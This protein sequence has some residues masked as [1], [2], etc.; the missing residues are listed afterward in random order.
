MP[1]RIRISKSLLKEA[2]MDWRSTYNNDKIKILE[3]LNNNQ[4]GGANNTGVGAATL[5]LT[6]FLI[7]LVIIILIIFASYIVLYGA[8]KKFVEKNDE[9]KDLDLISVFKKSFLEFFENI[10]SIVVSLGKLIGITQ[11]KPA[12]LKS[13]EV[14]N[15][16]DNH[17]TYDE[18]KQACSML[19]SRLA[20]RA[21]VKGAYNKG[22]EWCNYGWSE[23]GEALYPTQEKTHRML[24]RAGRDGECGVPGVNGGYFYDKT[25]K[26]GANCYGVKPSPNSDNILSVDCSDP[27]VVQLLDTATGQ[28]GIKYNCKVDGR[29]EPKMDMNTLTSN[30]MPFNNYT[31]GEDSRSNRLYI[32]DNS[33]ARNGLSANRRAEG[34]AGGKETFSGKNEIDKT[35]LTRAL[36]EIREYLEGKPVCSKKMPTETLVADIKKLTSS[37]NP[38]EDKQKIVNV[39]LNKIMMIF[40]SHKIPLDNKKIDAAVNHYD[41]IMVHRHKREIDYKLTPFGINALYLKYMR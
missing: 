13:S 22:A 14:F 11:E 32:G 19:G 27:T 38:T 28:Y 25:T 15:L 18:A 8:Y 31:W 41:D 12:I 1:R 40:K 23:G 10:R 6:G 26:L 30:I 17:Y 21:E 5:R 37:K 36:C 9:Y 24:K 34:F 7:R 35:V 16:G 20:T 29:V 3:Y 33:L 39:A 2:T 4:S